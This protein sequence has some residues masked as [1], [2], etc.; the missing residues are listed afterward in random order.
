MMRA[1][2]TV[3]FALIACVSAAFAQAE[4][5]LVAS[6]LVG[7]WQGQWT[8]PSGHLYATTLTLRVTPTGAAE[9]SFAWTLK[10]SPR[11]EEQGKLGMSG[12]EFVSGQAN[13]AARTLTLM[14]T[15]KDDPNNIIGLDRYRVVVSDDGRVMGGITENYG[16]WQG[17]ILLSRRP[18]S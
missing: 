5:P 10:R 11:P 16:N 3:L 14:G 15:R 7:T 6:D 1:V 17:Q 9:G 8:S 12:T 4:R 18:S 13:L 2:A